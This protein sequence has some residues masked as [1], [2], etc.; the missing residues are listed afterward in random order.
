MWLC[1]FFFYGYVSIMYNACSIL[2]KL[3]E[4]QEARWQYVHDRR[5]IF[6]NWSIMKA[7]TNNSLKFN[8]HILLIC[9]YMSTTFQSN[10]LIIHA[11]NMCIYY[12]CS[13]SF[14]IWRKPYK[15]PFFLC[16]KKS[17]SCVHGA[18]TSLSM[19]N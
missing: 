16:I 15:D 7:N 18:L 5:A 4:K 3:I 10:H 6:K 11:R 17:S 9:Q 19:F 12:A 8:A 14:S 2:F 13:I 1:F